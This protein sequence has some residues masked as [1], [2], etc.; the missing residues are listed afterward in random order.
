MKAL[1]NY[2]LLVP[3]SM[4]VILAGCSA[5]EAEN[6][7]G[8][9]NGT[10]ERIV[11]VETMNIEPI[12]FEDR[13]RINGNVTALD[14]A[15]ISVETAG[16]VLF[17]AERGTTVRKGDVI[18][19]LDDRLL[20]S[21]YEAT[22]TGYDLASDMYNRQAALYADSVISTSQYLQV[23]AQ[24]D[25]A[26]AQ[27]TAIEKQLED[28]Q[29]RAP[30]NGRVEER[31]TST[32]QFVGPGTPVLRL[33][34]TSR[35]RVTGGV[36]E[37]FTGRIKQGTEVEVSFRT[38]GVPSQKATVR[39]AGNLINPDSRTF[40][41]EV[42]IDNPENLI[43]PSMVA[44]MSVTRDQVENS[45]IVPRM[46]V[47]RNDLGLSIFVIVDDNGVKRAR[48]R[49]ITLALSSGDYVIVESGIEP[50]DEVV[51]AGFT[52]LSDGDMVNILFTRPVSDLLN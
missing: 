14:D 36:P 20:R 29:L 35:V 45:I 40:P 49:P 24:R 15:M 37:R 2:L 51:T 5:P 42:V 41:V 3:V 33:V 19:R 34:N 7:N 6:A 32:G 39:F 22:K 47:I 30:F 46:S 12:R 4:I 17:V 13:I 31:L 44:D 48:Q 50:G 1:K 52:N 10:R 25:Q 23:K 38:Y 11:S 28:A 9:G 8:N 26:K 16:Q 27:L 21:N 18:L 43:K